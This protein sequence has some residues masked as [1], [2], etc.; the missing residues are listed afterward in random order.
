MG[1]NN[2]VSRQL[3]GFQGRVDGLFVIMEQRSACSNFLLRYIKPH[4][5]SWR[6]LQAHGLFGDS[7]CG[8]VLEFF[9]HFLSF[10]WCLVTLNVRHLQQTLDQPWNM[11][12]IQKPLF[13]LKNIL[14]NLTKHFKGFSSGF[15]KL[16]T[17]LAADTLPKFAIH[18]GQN[19]TKSKWHSC[20]NSACS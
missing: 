13:G 19:D 9:Q 3:C 8:W 6:C 18:R 1:N 5:W 2:H 10:C 15:T 14:K 4:N 16:H 20:K 17:K 11:S 12:A 7:L